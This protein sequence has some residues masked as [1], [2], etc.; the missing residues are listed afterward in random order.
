MPHSGWR[1]LSESSAE[2]VYHLVYAKG[3]EMATVQISRQTRG[4]RA[5]A[6]VMVRVKPVGA[7]SEPR[8]D[9]LHDAGQ[10]PATW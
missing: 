7:A 2:G 4:F 9:E 8:T 1:A 3:S 10:R 5:G 6:L